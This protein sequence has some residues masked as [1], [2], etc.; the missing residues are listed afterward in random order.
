MPTPL[1]TFDLGGVLVRI[2]R[3]WQEACDR[4]G[5]AY[6]PLPEDRAHL[7]ERKNLVDLYQT[8]RI[9]AEGFFAGVARTTRGL[10]SLEEFRRIHDA[11]I[12]D[13]YPGTPELI[14]RLHARGLETGVLSNTNEAHWEHL[15]PPA[16]PR[17]FHTPTR[18]RHPHASHLLGLAKPDPAIYARFAELAGRAPAQIVFFDD[19]EENVAAALAAGWRA[20]QID[21]TG[22]TAG[23]IAGALTRLGLLD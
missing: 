22:D 9:D 1:I 6:R 19:L 15:A 5:V 20:F 11:W 21:H 14:D 4:A 23:Q 17:R 8:G 7:L 18:V 12:I 13:D 2:C 10:Y 3:T 16:G